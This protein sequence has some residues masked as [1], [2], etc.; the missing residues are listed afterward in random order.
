MSKRKKLERK[1][2]QKQA[3]LILKNAELAQAEV[4]V[5]EL[6]KERE[7]HTQAVHL[8]AIRALADPTPL[9][10]IGCTTPNAVL[11]GSVARG[12]SVADLADQIAQT[13]SPTAEQLN[14][15]GAKIE[16]G[17]KEISPRLFDR[18]G[19]KHRQELNDTFIEEWWSEGRKYLNNFDNF[20]QSQGWDRARLDDWIDKNR[21]CAEWLKS[22]S[23]E[24]NDFWGGALDHLH[25]FSREV[26]Y[27][28]NKSAS[29]LELAG[30]NVAYAMDPL[31]RRGGTIHDENI[32]T[33]FHHERGKSP[34]LEKL[35]THI[36]ATMEV[37][38]DDVEVQ[39]FLFTWFRST[40][41]RLEVGHKLAASLCL[42]DVPDDIEVK[43]PWE[44]WSLIV[45]DGVIFD[46]GHAV[47]FW[48]VGTTIAFMVHDGEITAYKHYTREQLK[49]DKSEYARTYEL[50]NNLVRGA[51]LALSNPAEFKKERSTVSGS[52]KGSNR[53]GPPELT[54]ARFLL[55]APLT[56]DLRKEVS[57][58]VQG[59]RKGVS[60]KVQF[61]VRGHWKNQPYG[62]KQSL[63]KQIWIKPF[64]KGDEEARV[65]LRRAEIVGKESSPKE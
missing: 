1:I 58:Y 56:I 5:K 60:P 45:P 17:L 27:P 28:P 4:K 25:K 32:A 10:H 43:A 40:F 26:V 62:P 2:A 41:A 38:N 11:A 12:R 29:N 9:S 48:V 34:R 23:D 22:L 52:S 57:E 50:I 15:A 51:C 7:L 39:E 20:M 18:L 14:R 16:Q 55:S 49:T 36:L 42:T 30:M 8:H 65:L 24:E 19:W 37:A 6:E 35:M 53:S 21:R 33:L 47:R 63:R 31:W 54:Q 44:A 13:R 3:D 61:L 59:T 46:P 64:W